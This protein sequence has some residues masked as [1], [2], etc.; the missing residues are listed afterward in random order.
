[1]KTVRGTLLVAAVALVTGMT[2]G[3]AQSVRERDPSWTV[4]VKDAAK[5]NPLGDRPEVVTGGGKLYKQRCNSCH[6]D[7]GR[8]TERA[9]SLVSADVQAQTD[10]AFFWK[11]TNGNTHAGMPSF[12]FLP[13]PQ[14]WQLVMHV[15][16]LG[17]E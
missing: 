15:R 4:P 11:I 17:R 3:V 10:G 13:G 5:S 7:A 9:P 6:G 16:A 8:G 12:S 14:R 1:V 2:S